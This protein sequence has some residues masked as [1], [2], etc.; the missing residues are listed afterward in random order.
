MRDPTDVH[1]EVA[2]PRD[3]MSRLCAA[4]LRVSASLDVDTVLSEVVESARA[5][6]GARYGVITTIDSTGQSQDFV[7]SGLTPK[8]HQELVDWLEG[9]RLFQH[10]RDLP[11][12]VRLS[13]LPAYVRSLGFSADLMPSKTLVGTPLRHREVH[14]G[15]FYLG[16]KEGGQDFTDEDEEILV[17]FALQAAT[18]IANART[19]RDERRARADLEAMER[20]R[21]EFLSLVSHELRA[22]LM[23]IKGG[24]TTVLSAAFALDAV[25]VREISRMV[26]E[27]A[28]HMRSLISDLLDAGRIEAGTLSVAPGPAHVGVLVDQARNTFHSGGGRHTVALDLPQDLPRVLAD[29][30]RIV[31]VLNNLFANAARHAPESSPIRVSAAPDGA[32]VAISV[33][34]RGRGVPPERLPHLFRKHAR[35]DDEGGIGGTGLG[36]AICRG[37]VEAHGGSIRAESGGAGLGMRVTF[38]LPVSQEPAASPAPSR[39]GS[40]A[41]SQEP[42]RILVVDDDPRTR[43]DVRKT[44]TEA[45]YA[46]LGTG[47]PQQVPLL[48]K[49]EKPRL[50]LLDLMLPGADGIELM[51]RVPG[52]ADLPVIFLSVYG[53]DETIARALEVG[54]TDYL[55]KPVSPTELTARVRAALRRH[56]D[57]E[58]FRLG[59]LE[60]DFRTRRV[61]VDGRPV[62][63]TATEYELLR[64]LATNAGH[65]VTHEELLRQVWRDDKESDSSR[66]GAFVKKLRH[67]L[68]DDPATPAYI[69]SVRGVGYRME[70]R[71]GR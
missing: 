45:G 4:I 50:V 32:H 29:R 9:P 23:A 62:E 46:P 51:E 68:G 48:L 25:E 52:L 1:R 24:A 65:V 31:Q 53:R 57:P 66:V 36:L 5:L 26:D 67:K 44:L 35:V 34:D 33:T 22:P 15:S 21:V 10:F 7:S 54:A 28:D 6:T 64:V 30:Q 59:G 11:G 18:A 60:I 3:R 17:L 61:T 14:V 20:S 58:T 63:L 37:L 49:K 43:R 27:Q 38:T 70:L 47:D 40:T 71:S 2:L 12:T 42:M 69:S 39:A 8:E 41:G 56:A 19:Y 16:D 55:V 13:D